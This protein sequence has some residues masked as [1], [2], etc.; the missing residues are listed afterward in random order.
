[1]GRRDD[2][3]RGPSFLSA[4]ARGKIIR[5]AWAGLLFWGLTLGWRTHCGTALLA[6]L[7]A[8]CPTPDRLAEH[9]RGGGVTLQ[10]VSVISLLILMAITFRAGRP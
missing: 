3:G 10:T 5:P 1:M 8:R 7:D 6:T 2:L 4:A 9:G